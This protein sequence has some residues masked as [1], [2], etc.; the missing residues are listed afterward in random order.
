MK[1]KPLPYGRQTITDEDVIAVVNALKG[2]YLTQGPT[3]LKFE[4]NFSNYIGCKYSVAVSNGTAALHLACIA[5]GLK[6]GEK[7]N[8]L[9]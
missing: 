5:L 1:N 9:S 3:I 6:N 4:E 2:D 8:N 7:V